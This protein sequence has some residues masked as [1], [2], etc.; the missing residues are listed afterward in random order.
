MG[1]YKYY[2]VRLFSSY[3]NN[4]YLTYVYVL[5]HSNTPRKRSGCNK[6]DLISD[7]IIFRKITFRWL[8]GTNWITN[9]PYERA[10]N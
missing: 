6:Y 3:L 10:I 1:I 8:Y 4:V 5:C 7:R 9:P 2:I